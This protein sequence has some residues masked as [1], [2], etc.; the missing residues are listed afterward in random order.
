MS[1]TTPDSTEHLARRDP[2]AGSDWFATT[3]WSLVVSAG[4]QTDTARCREAMQ[5]LCQNYWQ[6]LYSYVRRRGYSAEDAQDLTQEFFTRLLQNNRVARADQQK[7]KFRAFLLTSLKN[8][9]S[10]EWDKAHAQK[11]GSGVQPCSLHIEN[12]EQTYEMEP[13]NNVTAEQIFERRWALTLL[14]NVI[15]TLKAEHERAGKAELFDA[16]GP[17]LV[18]D[19]AA[20]PYAELAIR[21]GLTEGA[22]KSIVHR[23]RTRYRELL[24]QEIANTVASPGEVDEELSYLLQ[25]LSR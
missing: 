9:L 17:C 14:D 19:R 13:V 23:L 1:T 6:P 8:F 15:Q 11:R 16:V 20:Q 12:G 21:L 18:G 2:A 3:H 5:T 22:I 4:R 25:V 10:D 24:R 7:G